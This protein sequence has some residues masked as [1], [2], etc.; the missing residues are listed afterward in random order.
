M[1]RINFLITDNEKARLQNLADKNSMTLSDY[2]KAVLTCHELGGTDAKL[3]LEQYMNA[4]F[5]AKLEMAFCLLLPT[6]LYD[7]L[8]IIT[9]ST[10]DNLQKVG[11][12]Q[13]TNHNR[14]NKLLP[15][16]IDVLIK[17]NEKVQAIFEQYI[18]VM[19]PIINYYGRF[20]SKQEVLAYYVEQY[21][22]KVDN[23]A[24]TYDNTEANNTIQTAFN[25][26]NIALGRGLI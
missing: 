4:K 12:L 22:A 23:W 10:L 11:N 26:Y 16:I 13:S 6:D 18:A 19:K 5:F 25:F 21:K 7:E 1:A 2:I 15:K 8:F 9:K 20:P 17:D 14:Q 3:Y 24:S